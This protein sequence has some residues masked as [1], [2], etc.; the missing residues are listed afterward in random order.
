VSQICPAD[1]PIRLHNV[2]GHFTT[3]KETLSSGNKNHIAHKAKSMYSGPWQKK[4]DEFYARW[5]PGLFPAL[6]F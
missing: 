1:M 4:F 3:I 5:A 2:C 6:T